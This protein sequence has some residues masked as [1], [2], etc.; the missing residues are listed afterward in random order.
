[1][2]TILIVAEIQKD[3]I[4]DA[5][6][7]AAALAAKTGHDVKGLV[8]GQGPLGKRIGCQIEGVF[9]PPLSGDPRDSGLVQ[10]EAGRS[11]GRNEMGPV[12]EPVRPGN[13]RDGKKLIGSHVKEAAVTNGR[14]LPGAAEGFLGLAVPNR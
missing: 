6:F 14:D 8:L 3:K 1:M 13:R 9:R 12:V 11:I 10:S 2:G 5:T 4:R 7:E